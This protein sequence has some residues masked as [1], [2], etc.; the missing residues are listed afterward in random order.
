MKKQGVLFLCIF[1]LALFSFGPEGIGAEKT[2]IMSGEIKAI[3]TQYSTVVIDVP[4]EK[5]IFTVAGPLVSDAVLKKDGQT[6][7]LSDFRVGEKV[8]VKWKG[9]DWGHVIES[10]KS[11]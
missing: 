10:L 3:N 5:G 6:A 2:Y 1:A 11:R 4:L 7:T 8:T 9:T